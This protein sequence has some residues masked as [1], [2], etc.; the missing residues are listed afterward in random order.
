MRLIG[1][2][3]LKDVVPEMVDTRALSTHVNNTP[4]SHGA[5]IYQRMA[6]AVGMPGEPTSKL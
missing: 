1:A 4:E 6:T 3:T 2:P 5:Q